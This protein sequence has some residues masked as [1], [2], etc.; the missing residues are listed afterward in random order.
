VRAN[1][2]VLL[3]P[4]CARRPCDPDAEPTAEQIANDPNVIATFLYRLAASPAGHRLAPDDLYRPFV[5]ELPPAGISPGRLLGSFRSFQAKLLACWDR[6]RRQ[7]RPPRDLIDLVEVYAAAYPEERPEVTRI[8][9][10]TTYGR[11]ARSGGIDPRL[12]PEEVESRLAAL[13]AEVLF[14]RSGLRS[15]MPSTPAPPARSL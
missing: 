12:P 8:F 6:A 1:Q 2:G 3:D 5:P 15:G 9:L 7:G 4:P 10:V 11:T 13:T 14:G